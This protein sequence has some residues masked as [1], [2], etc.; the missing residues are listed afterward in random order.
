MKSV[1]A[2]ITILI[3]NVTQNPA[4]IA[5]HGLS[6]FIES[7]G[8]KIL[9]DCGQDGFVLE[10][11]ARVLGINIQEI[12][13]LI[14][15]HGHYDHTGG[16]PRLLLAGRK[17]DV[18]AHSGVLTTRYSM[19]SGSPKSNGISAPACAALKD[20]PSDSLHWTGQPLL[21]T[22]RIGVTGPVPRESSYEDTGGAFFLD[23]AGCR[24]DPLCDDQSIWIDTDQGLVVCAGCSHSGIINTLKYIQKL[25]PGKKLRAV[26]GGFHMVNAGP[27]RI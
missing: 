22:E 5:E 19:S 3:N 4:M 10:N 27:E 1:Q 16:V 26:I 24:P 8:K 14:L 6:L 23:D 7:D 11:N 9:F 21:I 17:V 18:Y 25:N 13:T 12:E 20:W 15:S 2:K